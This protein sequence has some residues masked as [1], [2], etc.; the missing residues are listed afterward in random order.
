[1]HFN[2]VFN[3]LSSDGLAG[4]VGPIGGLHVLPLKL[5][6]VRVHQVPLY[7]LDLVL[8]HTHVEQLVCVTHHALAVGV[9][10]SCRRGRL[11]NCG[12]TLLVISSGSDVGGVIE[13]LNFKWGLLEE[14]LGGLVDL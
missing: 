2:S 13:E 7:L 10:S 11:Q 6:L 8:P 14:A 5:K 12:F 4:V 9:T 3:P 1:V